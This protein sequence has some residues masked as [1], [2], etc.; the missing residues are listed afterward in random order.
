MPKYDVWVTYSDNIEADNEWDAER[1]AIEDIAS[2]HLR[3]ELVD[4]DEEEE[5]E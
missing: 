3:S 4:E 2:S 1:I 5:S